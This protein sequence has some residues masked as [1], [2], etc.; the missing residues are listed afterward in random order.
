M[1]T[2]LSDQQS[3]LDDL[4]RRYGLVSS[5]AAK[6]RCIY[7]PTAP[8]RPRRDLASYDRLSRPPSYRRKVLWAGRV[9]TQKN[10]ALLVELARR[11]RSCDFH[12]YGTLER[13]FRFPKLDNLFIHGSF[14]TFDEIPHE[15]Y[16]VFLYTSLW[17]GLPNILLEAGVRGLPIIAPTVGGVGE[18]VTPETGWPI[19]DS[20]D[21]TAF[22]EAV[23]RVSFEF[24]DCGRRKVQAMHELIAS[25]HAMAVFTSSVSRLFKDE[26]ECIKC[27][28]SLQAS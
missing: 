26:E 5:E 4:V 8:G 16:D 18:L 20:T 21:V 22:S 23:R 1:D 6:L 12:V 13:S 15:Q 11:N 10:P 2:I 17:D 7:Q 27:A 3:L 9:T 25:R 24:D 14:A 28:P 19:A